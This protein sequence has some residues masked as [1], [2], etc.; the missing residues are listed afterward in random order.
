MINYD[1]SYSNH[2]DSQATEL[3][4]T[5]TLPILATTE[6]C[7]GVSQATWMS[8]PKA[9]FCVGTATLLK[10]IPFV[11]RY[12]SLQRVQCLLV[13]VI[14][15]KE[16]VD[17]DVRPRAFDASAKRTCMFRSVFSLCIIKL[18]VDCVLTSPFNV[19]RGI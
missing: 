15:A 18:A 5:C 10:F 1:G 19:Y 4:V 9:R 3:P 12:Q 14:K 6:M 7:S 11:R 2:W 16:S 13:D 8:N 17:C